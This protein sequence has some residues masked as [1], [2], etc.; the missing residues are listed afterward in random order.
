[1]SYE[2][3]RDK[4][5][6]MKLLELCTIFFLSISSI[7]FAGDIF[8]YKDKHGNW[9]FSDKKPPSIQLVE[10]IEG[11]KSRKKSIGPR[12]YTLKNDN[13]YSLM[14]ENIFHIP[15][16][17]KLSDS[18]S[19]SVL[20]TQLVP[21][22]STVSVYEQS[23]QLS[24]IRYHWIYGDPNAKEDGHKYRLPISS[25]R[26][27][28]IGQS[29]RGYFS[30]SKRPN[31]YA[32]D[33]PMQV[34]T[35]ISAARGGTVIAVRDSYHMSGRS[36]Y[37]LDKA[38]Y[39]K[40]LHKDGTYAV[41]AHILHSSALVKPGD[42]VNAGDRLARSGSTGYSTGPHLH[43]VIWKNSNFKTV[44]VPFEFIDEKGVPFTPRRGMKVAGILSNM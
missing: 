8:K 39:V 13:G 32:V 1:M 43:F 28:Q 29:F 19:G 23:S 21:E 4:F 37:F 16:E 18:S 41:Y 33:I 27:Y 35:Y 7:S 20:H 10:V 14:V 25:N 44:S 38:N 36:T 11:D 3:F 26:K 9:V 31:I 12:V 6:R 22:K 2:L 5:N 17:I 40:I 24:K 15:V 34:G 30:H 42:I